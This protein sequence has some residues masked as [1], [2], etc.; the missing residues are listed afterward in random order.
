MRLTGF[1][2]YT[3][4][5]KGYS[6]NLFKPKSVQRMSIKSVHGNIHIK[7]IKVDE[8]FK[9]KDEDFLPQDVKKI[10]TICDQERS[11]GVG[12]EKDDKEKNESTAVHLIPTPLMNRLSAKFDYVPANSRTSLQD[13]ERAV[14]VKPEIPDSQEKWLSYSIAPNPDSEARVRGTLKDLNFAQEQ[15]K[16][17]R[18]PTRAMTVQDKVNH[19]HRAAMRNKAASNVEGL[20]EIGPREPSPEAK[21]DD[22]ILGNWVIP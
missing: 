15:D 20:L 10:E 8:K 9:D 13:D 18:I 4:L 1:V 14:S 7:K 5:P 2:E 22:Q 11:V 6:V 12:E 3:E 16:E 17:I 19:Q 21:E